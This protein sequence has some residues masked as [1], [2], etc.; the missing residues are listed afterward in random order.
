MA[1]HLARREDITG[2]FDE[3]GKEHC[4]SQ[5]AALLKRWPRLEAAALVTMDRAD[6][7]FAYLREC[8]FRLVYFHEFHDK[9]G[10]P[11]QFHVL[12]CARNQ[13]GEEILRYIDREAL[14]KHFRRLDYARLKERRFRWKAEGLT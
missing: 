9:A 8:G 11:D 12:A 10:Y 5:L 4:P 2:P 1:H 6:D 14:E 13:A 3:T 7:L